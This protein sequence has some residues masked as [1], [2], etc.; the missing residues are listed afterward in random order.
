MIKNKFNGISIVA[1]IFNR[2]KDIENIKHNLNIIENELKDYEFIIDDDFSSDNTR[3]A[4]Q[5]FLDQLDNS[6]L[7]K[8]QFVI[9]QENLPEQQGPKMQEVNLHPENG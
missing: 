7:K 9:N 6:I 8:I 2:V 1:P 5:L 4:I 3:E